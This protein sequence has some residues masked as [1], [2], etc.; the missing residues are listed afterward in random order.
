[1]RDQCT[2]ENLL[3]TDLADALELIQQPLPTD[4]L[5]AAGTLLC[6]YSGLLKLGSRLESDYRFSVPINMYWANVGVSGLAKTPIKQK[7]IDDPAA[8]IRRLHKINHEHAVE[9]WR[10]QC[11][12]LK[13]KDKP[14]KPRPRLP[15]A[16]GDYSPEAL[17]IQLEVHETDGLGLL[18]IRD[19]ISGLLR[20]LDNDKRSGRGTGEAQFLELFDGGGGTSLR[21]EEA[22]Q[23]EQSHV[24]LYGN[25][26]PEVLRRHIN[27]DD[28]TGKWA[29]ILFNQLPVQ[30][31][32]LRYDEPSDEERSEYAKA[33]ATLAEYALKLHEREATTIELSHGAR[34]LVVEW[35]NTHQVTA[36]A[37][38]TP[39]VVSAL[40]GKSS[41]HA[42]RIAGILHL[43]HNI[44][45]S[46]PE[47]KVTAERM[48]TAI[49]IVDTLITETC[50]FHKG[51]SDPKTE[52]MRMVHDYSWNKGKPK[53]VTWQCA[54]ESLCTTTE[55]RGLR[56]ADFYTAIE[57]WAELGFGNIDQSGK[58]PVYTATKALPK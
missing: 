7:L 6:G 29:R 28:S 1:M 4:P 16:G 49:D 47:P 17:G 56:S 33:Q 32:D 48:Q 58:A 12:G 14:P 54:K 42:H 23:Y 22:R 2:F 55:L 18:L 9:N 5:S 31:L 30:P 38:S 19:E 39:Q 44:K 43:V 13:G 8:V 37:P 36:L 50:L 35:F 51:P 34:R 52:L 3:P 27:G 45:K 41:A 40:L 21:V 11:E 46:S 26:Q 53:P 57:K 10:M 25:I 20:T 15:H 24:S